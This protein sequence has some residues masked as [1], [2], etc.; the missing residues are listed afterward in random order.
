MCQAGEGVLYCNAVQSVCC[1]WVVPLLWGPAVAFCLLQSLLA[2]SQHWTI[3]LLFIAAGVLQWQLLEYCIHRY[4]ALSV[5]HPRC[6]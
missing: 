1:R 3:T 6:F 2:A 5:T 4:S